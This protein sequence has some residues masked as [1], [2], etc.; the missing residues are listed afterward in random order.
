M[1]TFRNLLFSNLGRAEMFNTQDLLYIHSGETRQHIPSI[2]TPIMTQYPYWF[3]SLYTAL[4]LKLGGITNILMLA[5]KI[6]RLTQSPLL[7]IFLLERK[8]L[9]PEARNVGTYLYQNVQ[10]NHSLITK[11]DGKGTKS[12]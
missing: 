1:T 7:R 4:S 12:K 9:P 6:I 8:R 5:R 2:E 11:P 3:V 10:L